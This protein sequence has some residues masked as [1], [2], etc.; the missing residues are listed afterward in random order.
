MD[1]RS[2]PV[3][4]EFREAGGV[5]AGGELCTPC[6]VDFSPSSPETLW[7]VPFFTAVN[8]SFA[9]TV[10]G[11]PPNSLASFIISFSSR[12]SD[13]FFLSFSFRTAE[14]TAETSRRNSHTPEEC[15]ATRTMTGQ[16]SCATHRNVR[17]VASPPGSARQAG[18]FTAPSSPKTSSAAFASRKLSNKSTERHCARLRGVFADMF[19]A[20]A[21]VLFGGFM[22][23][24]AIEMGGRYAW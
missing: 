5:Q 6:S 24:L 3:D 15:C 16:S 7:A 4:C 19:R 10:A 13:A 17:L 12:V 21:Q 2:Q 8:C 9:S 22:Q 14:W 20:R 18:F 1:A 11:V 23:F